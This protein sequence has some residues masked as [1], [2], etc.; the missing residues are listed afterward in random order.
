MNSLYFCIIQLKL[1]EDSQIFNEI[2]G[3]NSHIQLINRSK[4]LLELMI[5]EDK[6]SDK[7]MELIWQATKKGDLEGRLSILKTFKEISKVLKQ[8]HIS[9][10][11]ENIYQDSSQELIPEEIEVND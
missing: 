9:M 3:P 4:D 8:K 7:E 5:K 2:Y 10:L 11:L 1:V 6:L